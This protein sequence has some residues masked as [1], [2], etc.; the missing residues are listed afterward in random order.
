MSRILTDLTD[1][2]WGVSSRIQRQYAAASVDIPSSL[3]WLRAQD[4]IDIEAVPSGS[5]VNFIND[6]TSNGNYG[7][8]GFITGPIVNANTIGVTKASFA[9]SG[10][11]WLDLYKPAATLLLGGVS[12]YPWTIFL[13]IKTGVKGSPQVGVVGETPFLYVNGDDVY[14][15]GGDG[16]I[17]DSS[18][19]ITDSTWRIVGV[20]YDYSLTKLTFFNNLLSEDYVDGGGFIGRSGWSLG[21]EPGGSVNFLVGDV[22]EM[23][24]WDVALSDAQALSWIDQMKT[25]YGI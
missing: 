18:Y 5:A 17:T 21:A 24:I 6:H 15:V 10:V 7:E 8:N 19:I 14:L 23:R 3:L 11:E 9:F 4:A 20:R 2:G 16:T 12:P 1:C 13:V 25:F 22:A